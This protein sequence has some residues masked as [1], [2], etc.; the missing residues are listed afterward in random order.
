MQQQ[1]VD[2]G[3]VEGQWRKPYA[4]LLDEEVKKG[5]GM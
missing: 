2:L 1:V 4:D 5:E 3:E